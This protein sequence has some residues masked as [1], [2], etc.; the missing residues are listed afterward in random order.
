MLRPFSTALA[1]LGALGL[2][3]LSLTACKKSADSASPD[4]GGGSGANTSGGIVLR[5]K[6]API[7]LKETLSVDFSLSGGGQTGAMKADM[8]GLLDVSPSGAE[9]LRVG[10]SVLEVRTFDLT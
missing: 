7:K 1:L 2:T 10:F 4:G 5:Y 3:S 9:R 8:T 6:S